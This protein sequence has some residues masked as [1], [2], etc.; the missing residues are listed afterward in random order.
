MDF[1]DKET[2]HTLAKKYNENDITNAVVSIVMSGE[3]EQDCKSCE[4]YL[5]EYIRVVEGVRVRLKEIHWS[6]KS[7]TIHQLTDGLTAMIMSFEDEIT[8]AFM[9]VCG[10][11]VKVGQIVPIIPE[12]SEHDDIIDYLSMQTLGIIKV[13]INDYR[14]LGVTHKLEDLYFELN[15][16]RYLATQE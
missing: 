14:F 2:L 15:K 9:G 11:K 4:E 8:E 13:L 12:A 5:L 3:S 6:T 1:I 10:F 16:F 7:S